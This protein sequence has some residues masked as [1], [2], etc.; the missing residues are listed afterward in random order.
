MKHSI[1]YSWQSDL[2][3]AFTRNFIEEVL[4]KA[5]KDLNRSDSITVEA[6]MDRDTA[7][8]G[9][10]PG[11]SE[12]IFQKIR[13]CDV[14]VGDVSIVDATKSRKDAGFIRALTAAVAGVVLEHATRADRQIKRPAPNPN[15]LLELGYA[16]A[17]IGW[18]R[19]ILV[20][21]TAYGDISALPFDLRGRRVVPFNLSSRESRVDHR[22]RLREEL[23]IA[24]KRA[25]DGML[26]ATVW[27]G[28]EERRWFGF[29][30]TPDRPARHNTLLVREVGSSG[31]YFHLSLIDGARTGSVAGHANYT[32]PDSAY[33]FIERKGDH[34]GCE[35]KF[36]RSFDGKERKIQVEETAGCNSFKGLG[37]SFDGIY[38]C[39]NDL[40]FDYGALSELDLQRLYTITGKYYRAF[41]DSFQAI[42]EQRSEDLFVAKVYSGGAKGLFR[43]FGGIVMKGEFGQLWAAYVDQEIIRYFTTE[44]EFKQKLPVTIARWVEGLEYK[45]VEYMTEVNRIPGVL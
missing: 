38:T 43:F 25:L 8:V 18:N 20:Q 1:F 30:H 22:A 32:G 40:L 10:T 24:L 3:P 11:I 4:G 2:D 16:A 13:N 23:G 45:T 17:N 39:S 9:G 12:T 27:R 37:A 36:R 15:V 33:A 6:V 44:P 28:M 34:G 21:N 5:V 7:G 35:I 19:V 29:W 14:F 31:F 42:S 26:T 41:V